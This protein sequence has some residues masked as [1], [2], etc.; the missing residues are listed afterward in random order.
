[1]NNKQSIIRLLFFI[2]S[3]SLLSVLP[4][5]T[6][7][8]ANNKPAQADFTDSGIQIIRSD[9][10][11]LHFQLHT[12]PFQI[13]EDGQI[14]VDS[15]E[16]TISDP[17]APALPYYST[18]IALPPQAAVSVSVTES[19]L[20]TRRA[21]EVP[22]VP[23]EQLHAVPDDSGILAADPA[24]ITEIDPLFT[25]DEA[26]YALDA[27]FPKVR[28]ELSEPLYLRDLR[29]VELKL[30]P[31]TYNPIRR[32]VSQT[33][34]LSV[35]LAF[36]GADFDNL[37][38]SP[39]FVDKQAQALGDKILNFD[40]AHAWRSLPPQAPEAATSELPIGA[41]TFK[42]LVDQDG[43]YEISGAELA[44]QGM[45]L[46]VDPATIEMMH[47]GLPVAFQF[48]DVNGGGQFDAGDKIRFYGWAFDGSRYEQMYV[49]DNVFWLW[50]GGSASNVP[51]V[52][53]EAG[54]GT[55]VTSFVD[56][57]T[58]QDENANFSG[59]AVEWA[60][61]PALWHMDLITAASG[62]TQSKSYD[63]ELLDPEPGAAGNSVV[64][65]LTTSLNSLL[66]T[67][68]NYSSRTYIN[69]Y[70]GF[71][72]ANW[73]GR[74]NFNI[75]NS[76]PGSAFKSPGDAG[77]PN[78]QV[79]I[80]LSSDSATN[81]TVYL[82]KI[83][84]SYTRQLKAFNDQLLFS[85][86]NAGQH[87]FHVTGF[88][89]SNSAS[90][91]VWDISDYRQPKQIRMQEPNIQGSDSNYTFMIGRNHGQDA[92]FIATTDSNL[93]PVKG[94]S[95]YEPVSVVPPTNKAEWIAITHSSLRDAAETLAEHRD[96]DFN[97]WVVDIEDVVNQV[98]YGFNT[99]QTIRNYLFH[100]LTNWETAP[101]YVTL[102]GDATRNPLMQECPLCNPWDKDTP[103]L[104]VTDF[105]FVDRWNG[106]VPSDFSMSLLVGNDL[107]AD[108]NIGRM[109][110]NTLVEA[111]NMVQKVIN[112]ENQRQGDGEEWQ[113][114][115]LFIADDPDGGGN[116]C[117]ENA[118][119]GG[120]IP[121]LSYNQTHL[122]LPAPTPEDTEAIR[123]EMGKQVNDIGTSVLNYRGHGSTRAWAGH[124]VGG[125]ILTADNV[126]F[127]Q[128]VGRSV[129]IISAD[130]LDGYF[131]NTHESALGE[132][133]HRLNGRGSVAHWSSAGFGFSSE[134][135][136]LH[137]EYYKGMFNYGLKE[138]GNAINYAKIEYYLTGRAESELYSFILLG[139]P[140]LKV[141]P[142][143]S[144]GVGGIF[145]PVVLA[146]DN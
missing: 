36:S 111:N 99:P 114:N 4:A 57:V 142:R 41:D 118:L 100:A 127:W 141:I 82:T 46:P 7:T 33:A 103:T 68:I 122:C 119:T 73:T 76:V 94:V 50:A 75:L 139:D 84:V 107:F 101:E 59:W 5:P 15:L 81:A 116:F 24:T 128:N 108:V 65:E 146:I 121:T 105:A 52:A 32:T 117:A 98:G 64:A 51:V 58:R 30:F 133:F 72:E 91:I 123:I 113:K 106:M 11:G 16:Q 31:L 112:Y 35:Q 47:G 130:C 29:L 49:N 21:V 40:Q 2:F 134:H 56:V 55:V 9:A 69:D 77:Y 60:N 37:K 143:S 14:H 71:G 22:P 109:P 135:T 1:M 89:I 104:L 62:A 92:H 110:A 70:T 13:T 45:S 10:A 83:A 90:A 12:T 87:D 97:T 102:F 74:K 125:S 54:A 145:M 78:N 120:Y 131:I 140:A 63:I 39:G 19:G 27:S 66:P 86:N 43:I 126:D 136:V 79:K 124:A 34:N 20:S 42:I 53:N 88:S 93:L 95:Y 18:L 48:I 38:P 80:E 67:I 44:A 96:N 23:Q 28:Y 17:G 26:I 25:K 144:F 115:F 6:F 138:I 137:T 61:E 85:I 132:T 3:L 8:S 129:V